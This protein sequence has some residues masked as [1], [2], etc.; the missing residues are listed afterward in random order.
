MTFA[1]IIFFL[2]IAVSRSWKRRSE[3]GRNANEGELT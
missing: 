3:I 2:A 1:S